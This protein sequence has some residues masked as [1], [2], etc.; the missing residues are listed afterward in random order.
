M[1]EASIVWKPSVQ[2][3]RISVRVPR[4]PTVVDVASSNLVVCCGYALVLTIAF[5]QRHGIIGSIL[6]DWVRLTDRY[7][8]TPLFHASPA[9]GQSA[10]LCGYASLEGS[11]KFG[12]M[13]ITIA[14]LF[15]SRRQW[16]DWSSQLIVVLPTL[17]MRQAACFNV[18][19]G[20]MAAGVLLPTVE[21]AEEDNLLEIT[22]AFF[23][24]PI[25]LSAICALVCYLAALR[26]LLPK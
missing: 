19:I 4:I 11:I 18:L 26:P 22:W 25:I 3:S 16:S 5:H 24:A 21:L 17:R 1:E 23:R 14:H 9:C 2:P 8:A 20:L 7:I 15:A 6:L 10:E 13:I 12:C